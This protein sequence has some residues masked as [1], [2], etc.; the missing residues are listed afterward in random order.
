MMKMLATLFLIIFGI[1]KVQA[2]Y[3]PAENIAT[4]EQDDLYTIG[5]SA[6]ISVILGQQVSLTLP[7]TSARGLVMRLQHND[8]MAIDGVREYLDESLEE[9]VDEST[10]ID[11][12]INWQTSGVLLDWHPWVDGFAFTMGIFANDININ[13]DLTSKSSV[14]ISGQNVKLT[15]SLQTPIQY[16]DEY[17]PYFGIRLGNA[18]ATGF[19]ISLYLDVGVLY[20][21]KIDY[22]TVVSVTTDNELLNNNSQVRA[23]EENLRQ[24]ILSDIEEIA[25]T[26]SII[27]SIAIGLQISF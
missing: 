9:L 8:L 3:M 4:Q 11:L 10:S 21:G 20:A 26:L 17:A 19:P 14:D 5:L 2:S 24:Q 27:P 15:A 6:G 23:E 18:L 25:D 16:A 1:G 13:T 12:E 7:I 22:Q